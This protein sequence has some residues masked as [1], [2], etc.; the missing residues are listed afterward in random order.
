MSTAPIAGSG[1]PP[2][3]R[4]R[5]VLLIGVV[6]AIAI[7]V[8]GVAGYFLWSR[9]RLPE[10]GSPRYEEFVEAFEVGVA[11]MDIGVGDVAEPNLNRAIEL[12]PQEP[13][14][15]ADRGLFYLRSRLLPQASSDLHQAEQLAPDNPTIQMLIGL[16]DEQEGRYAAASD[17][18]RRAAEKDADNVEILFAQARMIDKEQKAGADAE[19]QKLMERI[20]AVRPNNLYVLATRLRVAIRRDDRPAIQDTFARFEKLEPNWSPLVQ[21]EFKKAKQTLEMGGDLA[22]LQIFANVLQ[23]EPGYSTDSSEVNPVDSQLGHPLRTFLKLVPVKNR[24]AAPDTDLTFTFEQIPDAPSDSRWD[25]AA[26][27][28][29]TIHGS[30][31][32]VVANAREVRRIGHGVSLPSLALAPD[33]LI[34]FDWNNDFRTDL[35]LAGPGGLRFYQQGV[36]G[37][38][39]DVTAKMGLAAEILTRDYAAALA[40][41]FDLDGDLDIVLGRR[42]GQPLLLRNNSDGSFTAQPIFA[43]VEGARAFAWA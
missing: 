26:P 24:P 22:F 35:L 27:V 4:P 2:S 28:W 30:P 32:I 18:F 42:T 19:Y 31:A 23:S 40:V 29:L 43:G 15:W 37:N 17:R 10:P 16:L 41:E 11:G 8:L 38:F 39:T 7:A 9:S 13:A 14:A 21:S 12:I 1:S 36:D 20:L 34:P 5:P 25:V 6:A 33:G 3:P